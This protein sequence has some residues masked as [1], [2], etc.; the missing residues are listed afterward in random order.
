[1]I[2]LALLGLLLLGLIDFGSLLLGLWRI[3]ADALGLGHEL[4]NARLVHLVLGIFARTDHLGE[5][6]AGLEQNQVGECAGKGPVCEGVTLEASPLVQSNP[7]GLLCG[8][9]G[10]ARPTPQASRV[11]AAVQLLT[12]VFE[13]GRNLGSLLIGALGLVEVPLLLIGKEL[14]DDEEEY[15]FAEYRVVG[16]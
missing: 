7:N 11:E 12:R 4:S 9:V 6:S 5:P 14:D 15:E 13:L 1:V 8:K 10:V 16:G 2:I 3:H